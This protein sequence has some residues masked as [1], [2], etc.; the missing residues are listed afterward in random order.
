MNTKNPRKSEWFQ[1]K[2]NEA[3]NSRYKLIYMAVYLRFTT[4]EEWYITLKNV[5]H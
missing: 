5:H 2:A 1:K 3:E 4:R